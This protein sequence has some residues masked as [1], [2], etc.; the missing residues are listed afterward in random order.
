MIRLG[1]PRRSWRCAAVC[2]VTALLGGAPAHAQGALFLLVPFGARAVAL[3]E[4]V[5]ADTALGVEGVWWNAAA[6]AHMPAKEVSLHYSA[7]VPNTNSMM[8]SLVLPSRVIG[9]LALAGYL[10][11]YDKQFAT[12]PLT[13]AEIGVIS[14]SN[15]LLAASY[16]TPV[17]KRLAVGVTLK[18]LTA[19]FACSGVCGEVPVLSGQTSA[20]DVGAQYALPTSVPVSVGL[21]LRNIGPPLQIKD[22]E[23]ADPLPRVIQFGV[24]TRVPVAALQ[25]NETTLDLSADVKSSKALLGFNAGVGAALTYRAQYML[26]FGYKQQS[27][28]GGGPSIGIG[29]QRGAFGFEFSRRFDSLSAQF[30]ETPTYFSLRGRF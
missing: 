26:R 5:S 29:L 24:Q 1:M 4:A 14:N 22:A 8:L 11:S 21:S 13:G 30:G 15:A 25:Q 12:D 27:G 7:T 17:G 23:Q 18:F 16:A 20:L 2:A 28:E 6:L 10:V 19:R 3:G 9:T